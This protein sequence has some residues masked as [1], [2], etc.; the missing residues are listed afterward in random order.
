MAHI[1]VDSFVA[2]DVALAFLR[3]GYSVRGTA[4]SAE[5][6]K[7]WITLF[8]EFEGQFEGVIVADM[9]LPNAYDEAIK[10]VNYVAHGANPHF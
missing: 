1:T 10:G 6:A 2:T 5:K 3:E 8:P 9:S 4:R 7:A